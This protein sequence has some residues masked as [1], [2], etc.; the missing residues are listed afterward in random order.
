M[1][2][3]CAVYEAGTRVEG[4]LELA[5]ALEASRTNPDSFVWIGLCEPE[6]SEFAAVAEEFDLHPLAVEDAIHAHQRPKLELYG[7]TLFVVLK[8]ARYVD[9]EEVV[10]LSQIILFLGDRF[11][12]SVRHGSSTVLSVVR[13]QLEAE[14]D[15]LKAGAIGVLYAIMDRVVDDYGSVLTDLDEDI[16]D[17][18]KAVF[19]N[20]RANHA[21]R[22]Y[23]LKREVLEFRQAVVPLAAPLEDLAHG[24]VI[25][26]DAGLATYFRD[27]H[28]H[29]QRV[30][31]RVEAVDN[32]LASA[33][34][35]NLAQVGVR[36]NEDMRKISAWVAIIAM[37]TMIAGVYGMNFE[38][39]PELGWALGYPFA[40]G[41]MVVACVGLYV[42]F[43]RRG[44]L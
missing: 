4:A 25:A 39:M 11:L 9:H 35:A 43:R 41:L 42:L 44:W 16:E 32:L 7:P 30:A 12:V 6:E 29:L 21:E 15:R 18:E 5:N 2:V 37:P 3:D 27:V 19:S 17:V 26:A 28:D 20:D 36:Q 34:S 33:L 31:D 40:L 24:R 13:E 23:K 1:I 14:P 8:A 10:D 22:L 38:H